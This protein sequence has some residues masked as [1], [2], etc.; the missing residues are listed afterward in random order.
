MRRQ[1]AIMLSDVG[2]AMN[3]IVRSNYPASKLPEDLRDGVDPAATVTI[4][5]TVEEKPEKVMSLEEI[6]A[7]REP[8]YRSKEDVENANHEDGCSCSSESTAQ[9]RSPTKYRRSYNP[10]LR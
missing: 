7:L 6:W 10:S 3:S 8:P 5:V 1:D 4:T 2:M 9:A